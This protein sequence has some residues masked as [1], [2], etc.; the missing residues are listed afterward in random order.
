M[1]QY[2]PL[3]TI[4]EREITLESPIPKLT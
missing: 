4:N 1:K 2:Y 3:L